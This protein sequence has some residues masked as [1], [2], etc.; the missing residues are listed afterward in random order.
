MKGKPPYIG[1]RVSV[2]TSRIFGAGI[3]S[4]ALM[5]CVATDSA[6][7]AESRLVSARADGNIA[8]IAATYAPDASIRPDYQP[9]FCGSDMAAY[10]ETLALRR[11]ARSHEAQV[12]ETFDLGADTLI[13]GTFTMRGER[14][15]GH[16]FE[17]TGR[18][19]RLWSPGPDGTLVI[20]AEVT[21]HFGPQQDPQVHLVGDLTKGCGLPAGDPV[22]KAELDA[23]NARM[24]EAV[25]QHDASTQ[26]VDY[27]EDGIYMPFETPDIVGMEALTEHLTRYVEAGR[28]AEFDRVR[29]ASTGFADYGRHVVELYE[30]EVHWRAGETQGVSSGGG[31]RLWRRTSDEGLELL[32]Q[33]ATHDYRG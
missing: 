8:R 19:A 24:T 14:P 1:G 16:A 2:A 26:I 13:F 21:G 33:I 23:I 11:S 4:I 7:D 25:R 6:S 32:R 9:A 22:L 5:G 29:V 30:F 20:R 27:A 10:L 28:G 15:G 12:T 3:L 17:E 31:L 18:F